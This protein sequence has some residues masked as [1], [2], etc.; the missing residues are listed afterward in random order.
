MTQQP[1]TWQAIQNE[2][3]RRIRDREWKPGQMIPHEADLAEEL[4]CAR[5]TVNRAL[6]ELAA[7]GFLERRRKA[8]TRVALNP[9][10]KATFDIPIIRR[11]VEGRGARHGYRLLERAP[12][13]APAA[14]SARL[15]LPPKTRLLRVAALH[16]ADGA[17][18]CLEDR[19]L[20]PEAV[21][22]LEAAD[23]SAVS[24][25]EWLVQNVTLSGGG[26]EF[27]AMPADARLAAL[28]ACAEGAALFA[29]DRTTWSGAT[30][31]TV[32]RL[33]YAPGYRMVTAI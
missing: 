12:R 33:T 5:A 24:A 13:A 10:R 4:G 21:P 6:R 32:V 31:I 25:N 22:G 23:L 9:V 27:F 30:P 19:W 16:L 17:P 15:R 3:L 20:N 29:I 18:F 8:G 14:V 28:L 1:V 7:A 26:I 11:D 2:A